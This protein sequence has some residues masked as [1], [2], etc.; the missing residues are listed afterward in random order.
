MY[1]D[2]VAPQ[3]NAPPRI[4]EWLSEAFSLFGQQWQPWV[5]QG[6]VCLL[7]GYAPSFLG[8]IAYMAIIFGSG[9]ATASSSAPPSS[10][11]FTS[12]LAAMGALYGGIF[13]SLFPLV[14]L[15]CGMSRS[16]AMQLRGEPI[17]TRDVFSAG[18]VYLPALGSTLVV[19]VLYMV[20]LAFCILPGLL[21]LG[22]FSFVHPLVV[23]KR[24]G[25]MD[26]LRTS[27]EVTKPQMWMYLLWHLLLIILASI[28]SYACYIGAAATLP[29][30]VLAMMI[31]Y[32]DVI[33]LP[34]A[35]PPLAARQ[36]PAAPQPVGNYGPAGPPVAVAPCPS[37]GR[38]VAAG[39]VVCPYCSAALH[40]GVPPAGGVDP[41]PAWGAPQ[42]GTPPSAQGSTPSPT[43]PPPPDPTPEPPRPDEPR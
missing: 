7:I 16:A 8:M 21:V 17:R 26:A 25:V 15:W 28:G 34:G 6:L 3:T 41:P 19:G 36:A 9:L 29:I 30:Y 14:Y 31:S 18:D 12:M 38:P 35:L 13:L 23:E 27:W 5:G 10:T 11:A 43:P 39:A 2:T 33:G 40:G 24:M 32:R 22:L 1:R 37:C 42:P 20:G 4:G